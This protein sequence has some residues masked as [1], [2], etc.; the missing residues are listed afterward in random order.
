MLNRSFK[1]NN[2]KYSPAIRSFALTLQFYSAKAY[3]YVRKTFK[4]LL[5]NPATIKKWFSVVG[6][7][8]GF[9]FEAFEAIRKKVNETND[10]VICNITIDEMAIRKQTIFLNGKFYGGIDLGTGQDQ[11]DSDN[12]Q[13]ATNALVFLA[14]C[15][16]GHWKVQLGYFLVHSLTSNERANLLTKCL[17]LF[18]DTGA[19]CFSI[20]FD[21]APTNIAMCKSLSAN[22][23]YFSE[24]FQP[25]FYNPAYPIAEKKK[26]FIFWDACHTL[27]LVRNTIGDKKELLNKNEETIKWDHLKSLQ[28]I[29]EAQGLH[30]ADKFK[31]THIHYFKN[32]MNVR[33]AAQTLSSSVSSALMFCEELKLM[34][35]CKATAEFC[36]IFND[37]FDILN[38][39]NKLGKDDYSIPINNNNINKIKMFLN[40]FKLYVENLRFQP[41][42]QCP[43]GEQILKRQRK[44]GFIG[45]IICLTNLLALYEQ[46]QTDMNYLL[47]YKLSQDHLEVFF[48][49]MRSRGGFNNN[50]NAIQFRSAYKRVLVRHQVDGSMYG[51]C[52]P[53]DSA[54]IL[55][56]SSNKRKDADAIC[57][58]ED[59]DEEK[60]L[61]FN[62]FEHD[63]DETTR[64][65]ELEEFIIDIVK[66]TGGF[67]IRKI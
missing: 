10:S 42:Q 26:I 37:A 5:P 19:K 16:N 49:A 43:E 13:Q 29:Q 52:S 6:G 23:D 25:W 3:N 17:E 22:F 38:C 11:N 67:I 18:A 60:D 55:F 39:R 4:N 57:D 15:M 51:N 50:P 9:T 45:F 34:S 14:V 63:Y 62:E 47:S 20:T 1:S 36:K 30:A 21:G 32:K 41:T 8:P 28:N 35:G 65:P 40:A 44:T 54:S 59:I 56:V 31:K 2:A 7:E 48:S 53:L 66:Y 61:L 12:T 27:K 33:L 58:Y 64:M 46:I 24:H